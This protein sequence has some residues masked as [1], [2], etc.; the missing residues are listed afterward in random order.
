MKRGLSAMLLI[1]FVLMSSVHANMTPSPSSDSTEESDS[2][3]VATV[4]IILFLLFSAYTVY[5]GIIIVKEKETV[6]IERLGKFN[7]LLT[8]GFH[9]IIPYI[10][11]RKYYHWRYF[12]SRG[13]QEVLIDKR[14]F[15]ISTQQEVMD[16]P[17]QPVIS[18]DN[19]LI[20]LDCVLAWKIVSPKNM[21]YKTQNLPYMLAKLL[22]AQVR[23]IAGNLDVDQI[24]D[25]TSAMSAIQGT[26]D[27]MSMP[28]GVHIE[29]VKIQKVEAGSLSDVLARKKQA[30]LQNKQV[31]IN[32]KT[33]KQ[34]KIIT[35]EGNRDR[36][37]KE[38]EGAFQQSV[39][40]ARG[41][42]QAILNNANAEARVITEVAKQLGL[43][44]EDP[45][46]YLMSLK[47]IEALEKIVGQ[48]RTVVQMMPTQ[49]TFIQSAQMM[50]LNTIAPRGQ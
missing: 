43:S 34:T 40:R 3:S 14:A 27:R 13:G 28:W 36:M 16:F 35:A 47:Y 21:I 37:V 50:G 29:F 7:K 48:E 24:I 49:T 1:G 8:P 10:D 25:D 31:I 32:A 44:G 30:E 38:A 20:H 39:S 15:I 45:T 19:A 6:V 2:G 26:M 17:S 5:L 46:T 23:N 9:C 18:R 22:Q 11:R 42:A 12:E 4:V 33:V 41:Q